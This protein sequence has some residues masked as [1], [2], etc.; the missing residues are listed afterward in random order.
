MPAH[1]NSKQGRM[2]AIRR[3]AAHGNSPWYYELCE[4]GR[5]QVGI[6]QAILFP[7]ASPRT[8]K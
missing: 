1:A 8:K 3:S 7:T 2:E 4:R 5:A 6:R